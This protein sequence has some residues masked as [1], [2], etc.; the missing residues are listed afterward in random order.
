MPEPPLPGCCMVCPSL[1][2]RPDPGPTKTQSEAFEVGARSGI[3]GWRGR[4]GHYGEMFSCTKWTAT[5]GHLGSHLPHVGART[6]VHS[7]WLLHPE[8]SGPAACPISDTP[9]QGMVKPVEMF[10]N[11]IYIC[12]TFFLRFKCTHN[13]A[14]TT[15][16]KERE[17]YHAFVPPLF[18][19]KP[20]PYM[21]FYVVVITA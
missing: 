8:L 15:I 17:N 12:F 14:K 19:L 21:L 2:D 13:L 11:S 1:Q 10:Y 3:P 6:R 20:L 5:P 9:F 18:S 16:L 4:G 7:R